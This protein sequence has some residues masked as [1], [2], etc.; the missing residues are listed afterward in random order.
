MILNYID[1]IWLPIAWLIVHK[2]Q[3]W[4]TVAFFLSCFFM[5]R[6]QIEIMESIGHPT[7]FLPIL[8]SHVQNKGLITYMAFYIIF[9][10]TA[11]W[12]PDSN[13][14]I[15]LAASIS[16]FLGALMVSMIVMLL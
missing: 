4:M 16:I 6:L 14:H 12:S 13:K 5:M 2:E 10:A 11:Y 1:L 7:G 15:F 9:L 3:R 8:K